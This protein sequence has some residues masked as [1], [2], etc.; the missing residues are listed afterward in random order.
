MKLSDKAYNI[1]KWICMVALNAIGVFYKTIAIIWSLPYG[2]E[3][4]LTCSALALCIGTLIGIST[5]EYYKD[6]KNETVSETGAVD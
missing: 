5:A 1:L 4:A 2:N 3:V 6:K